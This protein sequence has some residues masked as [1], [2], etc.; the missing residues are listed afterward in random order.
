MGE[1]LVSDVE[2]AVSTTINFQESEKL[3]KELM[4]Y[5]RILF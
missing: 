5:E 2:L 3:G 1:E 4:Q